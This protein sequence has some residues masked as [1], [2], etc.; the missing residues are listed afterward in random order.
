M[1]RQGN[2]LEFSFFFRS[3]KYFILRKRERKRRRWGEAPLS[4]DATAHQA[5]SATLASNPSPA[6]VP[7]VA[8]G[9]PSHAQAMA[10]VW[11]AQMGQQEAARQAQAALLSSQ[12]AQAQARLQIGQVSNVANSYPISNPMASPSGMG[13]MPRPNMVTKLLCSFVPSSVFSSEC[14]QTEIGCSCVGCCCSTQ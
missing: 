13:L 2:F 10:A 7:V 8:S 11:Q 12:I 6:G 14:P 4:S 1:T 9:G 3:L 5:Q